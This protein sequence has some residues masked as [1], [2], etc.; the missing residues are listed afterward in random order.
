MLNKLYLRSGTPTKSSL[1]FRSQSTEKKYCGAEIMEKGRKREGKEKI[2]TGKQYRWWEEV[3][4]KI[5]PNT[6]PMRKALASNIVSIIAR[7]M[8][9]NI[10]QAKC[11]ISQWS[12]NGITKENHWQHALMNCKKLQSGAERDTSEFLFCLLNTHL[13]KMNQLLYECNFLLPS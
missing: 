1:Q 3:T 12:R 10:L 13:Q 9:I 7:I 8:P 4:F 5:L 2:Q 6:D 11:C